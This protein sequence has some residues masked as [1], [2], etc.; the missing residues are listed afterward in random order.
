MAQMKSLH[1]LYIDQLKDLYSAE[2]QITKALPKMIK[3]ATSQELRQAFE[4]HLA[5]TEQQMERVR[6][7][8]ESHGAKAGGKTCKGMQGIIEEAQELLEKQD[9][10]D[11]HVLDAGLIA[12]AQHVEHYEI[13]GYGTVC[14][15]AERMGHTRD[16]EMLR[17][18]L[19]EEEMTDQLLTRIA[20][21]GVNQMA[22]DSIGHNVG[23]G[24]SM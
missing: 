13:A 11:P 17:A 9:K 19:S 24:K 12:A 15:Y 1:E 8:L 18:T 2:S 23:N 10:A 7:I 3:A 4:Q 6:Q 14:A 20:E 16:L 5:Q 22:E 21:S